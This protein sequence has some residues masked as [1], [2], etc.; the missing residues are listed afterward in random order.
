MTSNADK[1]REVLVWLERRG[2][3]RNRD[4]MARYGIRSAKVFGVSVSTLQHLA[5]RL[6]R[7]GRATSQA[8]SGA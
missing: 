3:Q 1:V 5:K 8:R 6:G 7:D 4:G 2:T